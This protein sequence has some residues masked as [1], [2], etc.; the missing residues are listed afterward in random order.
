[1]NQALTNDLPFGFADLPGSPADPAGIALIQQIAAD[2]LH[3]KNR[4]A[5]HEI[6]PRL[7]EAGVPHREAKA[8]AHDVWTAR[9][10]MRAQ[11]RA[12]GAPL[13]PST[14]HRIATS[15]S[16]TALLSLSWTELGD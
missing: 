9:K 7:K 5:W 16:A 3:L 6:V 4:D 10:L 1:M 11:A 2:T 15:D 13:R 12:D 14:R 8:L